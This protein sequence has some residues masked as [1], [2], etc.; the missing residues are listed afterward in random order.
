VSL[1]PSKYIFLLVNCFLCFHL[2]IYF[3]SQYQ[4]P[5]P[6]Q[7]PYIQLFP[8]FPP[9]LLL[10]EEEE[11]PLGIISPWPIKSLQD[12]VHPLPLRQDIAAQLGEWDPQ[13]CRRFRNSSCSSCWGTHMK[14]KLCICVCVGGYGVWGGWLGVNCFL[15]VCF[16]Y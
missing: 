4:P 9:P 14:T 2:F 7:F 3:T 1:L 16:C 12:K 10:R 5:F 8:H 11:R 13:A 6:S 15:S